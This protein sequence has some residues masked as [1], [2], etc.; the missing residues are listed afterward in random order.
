MEQARAGIPQRTE[1]LL[2][3]L[4]H[5]S[6]LPRL[7]EKPQQPMADSVRLLNRKEHPSVLWIY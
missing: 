2:I 1:S 7:I 4:S 5:R 6:M 3:N